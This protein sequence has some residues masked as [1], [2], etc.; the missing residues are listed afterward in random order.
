MRKGYKIVLFIGLGF[1]AA[2]IIVFVI[3]FAFS[4]FRIRR[5][6]SVTQAQVMTE[7]EEKEITEPFDS[8][9]IETAEDD[10]ILKRSE[11]GICRIEY[12]NRGNAEYQLSVKNGTLQ[13][14]QNELKWNDPG[15][16]LQNL[17]GTIQ[18]WG[19]FEKYQIILYLPED[20]YQNLELTDVSGDILSEEK[21]SFT[22]VGVST[23][24]GSSTLKNMQAAEA[25]S[26]SSTSG[27]VTVENVDEVKILTAS[28]VSGMIE[29]NGA[30]VSV[31]ASVSNVSGKILLKNAAFQ[32]VEAENGSGEVY[33]ENI[34]AKELEIE[35]VSGDV[36]GKIRKTQAFQCTTVSGKIS[37]PDGGINPWSIETVSGDIQITR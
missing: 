5:M 4:G 25:F 2:A 13:L 16:F 22:N 12:T 11:S 14:I 29:I 28:S 21:L 19:S 18:G 37:V 31:K 33:L 3:A 32:L 35:T 26:V 23:V 24:S 6:V 20:S 27:K 36:T 10:V 9:K 15:S 30:D 8:I 34:D 7:A 1:I 17:A